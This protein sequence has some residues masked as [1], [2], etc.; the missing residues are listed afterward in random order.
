MVAWY[1]FLS[2][3]ASREPR[4]SIYLLLPNQQNQA[5][6]F[7]IGFAPNSGVITYKETSE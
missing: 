7:S 5:S 4:L 1:C 3:K 2:L 6:I